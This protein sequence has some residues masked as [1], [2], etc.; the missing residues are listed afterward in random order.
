MGDKKEE[1][2]NQ[3]ETLKNIRA[4]LGLNR[5]QFSEYMDIPIRTLEEWE[6]GRRKMPDYVLRLILYYSKMEK[7]LDEK[8]S[9]RREDIDG[10]E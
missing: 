5:K 4:D 2:K 8:G 9:V 7:I 3:I 10:T 6:A 1:L